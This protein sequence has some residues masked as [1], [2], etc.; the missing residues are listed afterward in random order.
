MWKEHATGG[1][2]LDLARLKEEILGQWE[3]SSGGYCRDLHKGLTRLVLSLR[4][5]A[6]LDAAK[7]ARLSLLIHAPV[8]GF[9]PVCAQAAQGLQA[10]AA[11]A[12][13][14]WFWNEVR[15][16]TDRPEGMLCAACDGSGAMLRAAGGAA[17]RRGGGAVRS[18]QAVR[19]HGADGRPGGGRC[20]CGQRRGHGDQSGAG[21][22]TKLK[23][24]G[25]FRK[26]TLVTSGRVVPQMVN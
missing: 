26:S 4:P 8:T 19:G 22:V 1:R 6:S 5:L 24:T 17:W 15:G 18:G 25:C 7:R 13:P 23:L 20:P 3:A 11:G 16:A 9:A 10:G 2:Q 12:N 14:D 21:E